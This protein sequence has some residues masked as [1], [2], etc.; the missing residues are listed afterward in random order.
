MTLPV[1]KVS[2]DVGISRLLW[3]FQNKPIILKFLTSYLTQ[4]DTTQT[5]TFSVLNGN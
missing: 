4:I 1:Q 5:D 3:Q 2:V